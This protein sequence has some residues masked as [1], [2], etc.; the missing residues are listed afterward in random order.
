MYQF[1]KVIILFL[2]PLAVLAENFELSPIFGDN[3]VLQRRLKNQI[4][5]KAVPKAKIRISF[6]GKSTTGQADKDGK[7]PSWKSW[8]SF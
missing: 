1:G 7:D 6:Y 3:M 4:W 8:W 2:L 5:G